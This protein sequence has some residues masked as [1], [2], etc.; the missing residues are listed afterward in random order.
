MSNVTI[1]YETALARHPAEVKAIMA[2][3]AK[4][5]G[6]DRDIDPT[7]FT[8]EYSW[9]VWG[10][11]FSFADILNGKGQEPDI[12]TFEE[13]LTGIALVCTKGRRWATATVPAPVP[14]EVIAW[15][16]WCEEQSKPSLPNPELDNL[17]VPELLAKLPGLTVIALPRPKE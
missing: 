2:K 17:T 1:S 3:H 14:P 16:E 5:R 6:K 7:H 11:S 13:R 10:R 12:R 8:W 9:G 4:T 15:C